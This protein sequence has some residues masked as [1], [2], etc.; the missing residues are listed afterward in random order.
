[1]SAGVAP[2]LL[3]IDVA[4][5][6]RKLALGSLEGPWQV[7]AELVRNSL[8]R[9]AS[10]VELE[11]GPGGLRIRDDGAPL[12]P[13]LME[14]LA[15]L[16]DEAAQPAVRHR[17]L[18]AVEAEAAP[19][20]GLLALAPAQL[21]LESRAARESRSLLIRRGRAP[22]V[23]SMAAGKG[24]VWE[25]KGVHLD[26]HQA[27]HWLRAVGRFAPA[28]L[29][30]DGQV[31]ASGFGPAL[32]ETALAPP[33]SG[34]LA[35]PRGA[36]AAR[37]FLLLDGMVSAHL[38]LPQAPGFGAAVEM[39]PLLGR[40]SCPS[41]L[42]EAV[43]P[44]LS[45]L[46]EQATRLALGLVETLPRLSVE[47]RHQLQR[48]LLKAAERRLCRD[49]VLRAAVWPTIRE[50]SGRNRAWLSLQDLGAAAGRQ[51][52]LWT[53]APDQN[54]DLFLLPERPVLLAGAD[55]KGRL[56]RLLGL[57]FK[58]PQP[59]PREA[60]WWRRLV[61]AAT[62]TRAALAA[63]LPRASS[64]RLPESA[65]S[66][67]ERALARALRGCLS[68]EGHRPAVQF[69][70]GGGAAR[71]TREGHL[72]LPRGDATVALA[73]RGVASDVRLAYPALLAMEVWGP[74]ASDDLR[75]LWRLPREIKTKAANGSTAPGPVRTSPGHMAPR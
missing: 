35:L 24:V 52:T 28:S 73:A 17:F 45:S 37:V 49:Q 50:G 55:L 68:I 47:D 16:L 74:L 39:R 61:D 12:S 30:L 33:L 1:M 48:S 60:G 15:G 25:L 53:L 54:P 10:R 27:R 46:V 26:R 58:T 8:A 6:I 2:D 32:A 44:H 3:G 57:S 75:L 22:E 69:W 31:V 18:I 70:E 7:P 66:T 40:R 13:R 63:V 34:R 21:R 14:A 29:R 5:E 72:L 36:E 62:A 19:L 67:E 42:R 38:I 9:G 20:L 41:A 71:W 56:S 65:L 43:G 11:I 51:R 59:R 4:S 23:A 64:T